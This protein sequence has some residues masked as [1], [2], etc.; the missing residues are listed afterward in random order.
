M[1]LIQSFEQVRIV[2]FKGGGMRLSFFSTRIYLLFFIFLLCV[3]FIS[4][5][6]NKSR[7]ASY[8]PINT[9]S[10]LVGKPIISDVSQDYLGF[11]L[12]Q[13]KEFA[14]PILGEGFKSIGVEWD[15]NHASTHPPHCFF[16]GGTAGEPT[17]G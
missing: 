3:A 7:M 8:A 2:P 11:K 9:V 5:P 12:L 16:V 1:Y 10:A 15:V 13:S 4:S 14:Y 17:M 6:L